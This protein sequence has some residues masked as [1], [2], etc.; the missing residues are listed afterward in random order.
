MEAHLF[1][2]PGNPPI[3]DIVRASRPFLKGRGTAGGDKPLV[4]YLPAA[5]VGD[6]YIALTERC[7]ARLARVR[8]I[9]VEAESWP[10]IEEVLEM[11]SV[12]YIPGG[13]TYALARRLHDA[14]AP[15]VFER[16]RDRVR[17]GLPLIA[18]SAGSVFCGPNILTTNDMNAC[19]CTTFDGMGLSPYNF[20]VHYP[21]EDGEERELRDGR[22]WEYHVFHSNPVLALEDGAHI[23]IKDGQA[24]LVKGNCWLF[25]KGHP[26]RKVDAGPVDTL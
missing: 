25:E 18:F 17:L 20:N 15:L 2:T 4:A 14:V 6:R 9:D 3:S 11:V 7:F 13:N 8:T 1:S 24:A 5:C 12:L 19:A 16:I 21:P 22:I 10:H 26:K 23:C